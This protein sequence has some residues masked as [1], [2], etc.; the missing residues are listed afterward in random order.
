MCLVEPPKQVVALGHI[1]LRSGPGQNASGPAFI[2]LVRTVAV[3]GAIT[4][5]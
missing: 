1:G 5:F 4:A 2:G 3:H